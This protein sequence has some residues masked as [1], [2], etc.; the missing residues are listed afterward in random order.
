MT[1]RPRRGR[2]R[3]FDRGAALDVALRLFWARGYEATST[4]ELTRAMGISMPSLYAAFGDKKALFREVVA[5]YQENYGP[6][7]DAEPREGVTAREVVGPLLDLLATAYTDPDHPPGCLV[8]S[9]AVNC[10]PASADVEADLRAR[11]NANVAALEKLV[12]ADVRAGVLPSGTDARGLA[13]F[14]GATIQGMSQQARDGATRDDLLA[15]A[16]TALAAWP[17]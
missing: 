9:A 4:A 11:R 3:S 7:V 17:A 14:L 2:P 1:E 8:I 5:H 6:R 10:T 15:I 12:D 16:R 13:R